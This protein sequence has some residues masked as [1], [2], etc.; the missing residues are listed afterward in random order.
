MSIEYFSG[1]YGTK[2]QPYEICTAHELNNI[3]LYPNSFFILK[4]NI[5]MD[6][7]P[8]NLNEGWLP[9]PNFTGELDGNG[10][11]IQN[12]YINR[13]DETDVGLFKIININNS[14]YF[15]MQRS[16]VCN[17]AILNANIVGNQNVGILAGTLQYIYPDNF[18][19]SNGNKN[20][21]TFKNIK[22]TGTI[23]GKIMV[24]S[25]A[26]YL[27]VSRSTKQGNP[28]AK[29]IENIYI[30]T[31]IIP[32]AYNNRKFNGFAVGNNS[33][34]VIDNSD[35][36]ISKIFLAVKFSN[37]FNNRYMTNNYLF[38]DYYIN[39]YTIL[40]GIYGVN[41]Y[42]QGDKNNNY[43]CCINKEHKYQ[44]I[45]LKK[46]LMYNIDDK[47]LITMC[48]YFPYLL[49]DTDMPILIYSDDKYY[50]YNNITQKWKICTKIDTTEDI[51]IEAFK[52]S[53]VPTTAWLYFLNKTSCDIVYIDFIF[54]KY[55][56]TYK[57]CE[58]DI[59]TT[60]TDNIIYTSKPITFNDN[61]ETEIIEDIIGGIK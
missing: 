33:S 39:N 51:Y 15:Y 59:G 46:N 20:N 8:Y 14:C 42:W 17:L 37:M 25:F 41:D 52:L 48:G 16:C 44:F 7:E 2:V 3:R 31:E 6:I 22:L 32:L 5:N 38:G 23:A 13:P 47:S 18:T 57:A 45:S 61:I 36:F 43:C 53:T 10:Y 28:E 34:Y 35:S 29:L 60:N 30:D 24:G 27:Q 12:L 49:L 19:I 11:S 26:G 58:F 50:T 56:S 55:N 1:G 9:I 21:I 4:N 40:N 54:D